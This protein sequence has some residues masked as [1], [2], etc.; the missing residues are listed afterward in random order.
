MI[1]QAGDGVFVADAKAEIDDVAPS[2]RRRL[3]S[4]RARRGRRHHRRP[5]LQP[6]RP[7]AGARRGRPGRS[8]ASSSICSTPTRAASS[9]CGSSTIR[10]ASAAAGRAPR[11]A[12][13]SSA[14]RD[15]GDRLE[16]DAAW[17]SRGDC[18]CDARL[19]A[20][21]WTAHGAPGRQD[22]S[23]VGLAP[24]SLAAFAGR[25]VGGAR[26]G[27]LRF[28]RRRLRLLSGPRLAD[29]RRD[30]RAP[31][32]AARPPAA[33]PSR[34]AGGSASAI[35][36]PASGGSAAPCWSRPTASPGCCRSPSSACRRGWRSSRPRGC[37]GAR[38]SGAT[39]RPHRRARR[40][41][42]LAEWLRGSLHRLSVEPVGYRGDAGAAADAV[43]VGGRRDG[44]DALAVFVFA[45]PALLAGQRGA[46]R[47]AWRSRRCSSPPM[48][49]SAT[50]GWPRRCRSGR[51][52]RCRCASSSRPSS[53]ARNGTA[54][55]RDA[56]FRTHARPVSAAP[57]SGRRAKPQL[58]LW[59]ET[60][61]PFL[62]TERPDALAAIGEMLG[63]RPDA[64]AGA[65]RAEG[66]SGRMRDALLQFRRR[67]RRQGRD[68]RRRR[69]GASR[70]VRR[71]PAA[72]RT[73]LRAARHRAARRH[74]R[75]LLGRRRAPSA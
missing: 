51:R 15:A 67:D 26:P 5:D 4:R 72:S 37:A 6:A 56:I 42:R 27:A 55:S 71:V 19:I 2:D 65:V 43:G 70:A 47:S 24:R 60:S 74:S 50:T 30:R 22:H 58:I 20:P 34:S 57:P 14:V 18:R 63:R 46:A 68:R 11:R 36:S 73:C 31:G 1:T 23:A 53:R 10:R 49:A 69:Q 59:P 62:F 40:G 25:R 61:V 52:P 75:R 35:S 32:P 9:A 17:R 13:P 28:L 44:H 64:V 33:A 66:A 45:V 7:R 21:R 54:A 41:L 12:A 38:S 48:S 8:R 39:A 16:A 3:R 29:R